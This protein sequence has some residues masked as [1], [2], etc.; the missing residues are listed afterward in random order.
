VFNKILPKT[1]CHFFTTLFVSKIVPNYIFCRQH[2]PKIF[3]WVFL[4]SDLLLLLQIFA[5]KTRKKSF[6][7]SK[8]QKTDS[9]EM[10]NEKETIEESRKYYNNQN[11]FFLFCLGH[12]KIPEC[13]S[14]LLF[15]G[16]RLWMPNIF[17]R[18]LFE[19][20]KIKSYP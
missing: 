7:P 8:L 4:K 17:I 19:K 6:V 2:L 15:S 11:V 18:L 14:K 12:R 10:K 20:D 1:I 16:Y 5:E 3:F 13:I 9:V